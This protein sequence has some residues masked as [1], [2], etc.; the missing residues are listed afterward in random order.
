MEATF[1]AV[2]AES[3]TGFA[4]RL[5]DALETVTMLRRPRRRCGHQSE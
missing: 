4:G 3:A 5:A 1:E 2:C